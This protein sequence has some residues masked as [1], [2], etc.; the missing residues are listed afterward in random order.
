MISFQNIK[1]VYMAQNDTDLRKSID[2]YASIVRWRF[3]LSPF[4]DIIGL[5]KPQ[6]ESI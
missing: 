2:D 1:K 6:Y 4:D 5:F 3:Q